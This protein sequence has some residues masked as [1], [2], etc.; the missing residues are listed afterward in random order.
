MIKSLV[1]TPAHQTRV[2]L[3]FERFLPLDPSGMA[4]RWLN[5]D[6]PAG[7][8]I[9]DPI[10]ASPLAI[11]EAAAAGY[12]VLVACNNPVTAFQLRLLASAP[13][14]EDFIAV[15]REL[16]DQKKGQERLETSIMSL[17]T[18]RCASC[19]A[20]IQA[21]G[22]LW[23]R[24][25]KLP[26]GRIYNCP[27]CNDAGEHP[28][29]D[30]DIQR[31]EQI[32]RS[33]PMY[34]SR[35]LSKVLGGNVADREIVEAAVNIYPVRSLY[36]L[37]TLMNKMEGMQLSSEKRELLEAILLS[38]MYSGN[39]IWSW[40]EERERPRL[41]SMPTRYIEKNL[42]LEI[43]HAIRTWTAE[44]PRVEFTTWP[45][46]PAGNGVCLF[47]G[48]MRD[49][50]Q[51][52]EGMRIDQVLCVFPRPNQ[53]FWTL[54][55]LWASWLWGREKAGKFSQVIERR[56]FDWYWHT[57]ALHAALLPASILAGDD[58]PVFGIIPEPAA[59]LISAVIQ[60]AAISRMEV[61]GC[62]VMNETE[63]VQISWKTGKRDAVFKPVNVQKIAREAM[64]ELL[65]EIG[66]PT[67]YIELHTAAMTALADEN[68]FPPTIQQ[69]TFE[70]SSEVQGALNALLADNTF[71]RRL[72]ATAQDP[73]SGLWWLAQA[74]TH[75]N[76]LADRL[77]ME[78]RSWLQNETR[79]PADTL[80]DRINQRFSGYLT[81]PVNLIQM[82]MESY[83]DLEQV[84][85]AWILKSSETAASREA[86]LLRMR[87]MV[88]RLGELFKV[89]QEGEYPIS[90]YLYTGREEPI[91]RLY[92]SSTAIV[93]RKAIGSATADCE[94]VFILP[95]SRAGLLKF[96]LERDPYLRELLENGFHFLKYRTLRSIA[97]RADLTLEL[98]KM[99]IDTDP[100]SLE[101]NTQLS[102]F[103]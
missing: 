50:A 19:G 67:E 17:Y 71:L 102:M 55:S 22:F 41:L 73:E 11:L 65:T 2:E 33:E 54:C 38:L 68:T 9:L 26:H 13:T 15:I 16:G 78:L 39:A 25:E 28:I 74:D 79:I 91:Y 34:R 100:L 57:T 61:C 62:A 89:R 31:I 96:K 53:A 87:E 10:C 70:K 84:S 42:W 21:S 64:R 3:P 83:A 14:R 1:Y 90:W 51:A 47:P 12:R 60:S 5:R 76:P 103:L 69:L 20:E 58:V 45:V 6:T 59:G 94:T 18:T 98:W 88:T 29:T 49:L 95:G 101:E 86:D 46:L 85:G 92:L 56:R 66:E 99:L 97:Q 77:E 75:Q 27:Y 63:P 93:D 23:M 52:A 35:A 7:S 40:P 8:T 44:V 36:V 43:D 4:A 37:F 72:D 80:N 32:Q 48:R 24:G 82:S 81:P 30:E